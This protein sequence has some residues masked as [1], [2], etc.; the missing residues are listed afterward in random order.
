MT[1][2]PVATASFCIMGIMILVLMLMLAAAIR[3][4]PE[5]KRM[6]L[7]EKRKPWYIPMEPWK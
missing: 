4:V 1:E 3:I 6:V 2:A 5:G 7:M